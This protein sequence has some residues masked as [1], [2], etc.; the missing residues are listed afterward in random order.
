[1][2]TLIIHDLE[3]S[4]EVRLRLRAEMHGHA[5][6][7]EIR[8]ILQAAV[9]SIA[10]SDLWAVSRQLFSG[11]NSIDLPLLAREVDRPAPDFNEDVY[12]A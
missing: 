9:S 10:G 2:P 8:V 1:M 7:E 4:L 5:L 6:E 11:D 12:K 3:D